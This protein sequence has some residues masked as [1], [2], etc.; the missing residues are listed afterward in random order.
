[1]DQNPVLMELEKKKKK[2]I[3]TKIY[4]ILYQPKACCHKSYSLKVHPAQF[5]VSI[6][7]NSYCINAQKE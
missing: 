2:D 5:H 4:T 7:A 1:M 3:M 6:H